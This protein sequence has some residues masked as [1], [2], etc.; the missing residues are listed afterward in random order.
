MPAKELRT[1]KHII[2]YMSLTCPHC[3]KAAYMLHI[4]KK[5]WPEIPIYLVIS[6]HPSQQKDF[7]EETKAD[8]LPFLLYKDSEA[9]R[10]MAGDGVPA[11]Y[12]INNGVIER[13][14]T[15]LQL[16]PADIKDWLKD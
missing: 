15:Y 9:F 13:E 11:I 3:R 8:D 4:I 7:F 14:A 16:D 6:G 5:Q 12:W 1:G 2:A 10:Q